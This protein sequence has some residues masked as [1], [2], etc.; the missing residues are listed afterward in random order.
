MVA[1]VRAAGTSDAFPS[2]VSMSSTNTTDDDQRRERE[3]GSPEG[4][5]GLGLLLG[6]MV[7][8]SSSPPAAADPS[9]EQAP[10]PARWWLPG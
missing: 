4:D 3:E 8:W 1:A 9:A 2:R 5:P 7:S 10:E 6:M